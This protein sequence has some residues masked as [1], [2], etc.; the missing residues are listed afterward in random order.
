MWTGGH[1]IRRA[2]L[3]PVKRG[4]GSLSQIRAQ[5]PTGGKNGFGRARWY[6]PLTLDPENPPGPYF[7]AGW[8]TPDF[9]FLQGS[10]TDGPR[11]PKRGLPAGGYRGDKP[12]GGFVGVGRGIAPWVG[13]EVA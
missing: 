5:D 7:L 8:K 9:P 12:P 13:R 11:R 2:P 4:W 3:P 6:S 10:P 1:C